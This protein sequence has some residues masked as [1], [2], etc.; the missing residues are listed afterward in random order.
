VTRVIIEGGRVSG[1]EAQ[2]GEKTV[3]IRARKGVIFA[4]GGFAHNLDLIQLHQRFLYGSCAVP[5]SMGDFVSIA[6]LAGARMGQMDL[7]WRT[8]VVL[9]EALKNHVL[10]V[11]VFFVPSDSMVIVNKYGRRV[12]DE[13]RDYN[14]RTRAHFAY[15]PVAE[16]YPNQLLFMVFDE[17][18]RDAFGGSYPIPLDKDTPYLIAGNNL[19][20]LSNMIQQR[21]KSYADRTGGVQLADNFAPTLTDTITRFNEFAKNGQDPEFNR[22]LH[23]YDREWQGYFSVMRAGSTQQANNMPNSTMY[24]L[25]AQGPYYAIVLAPGALD[26]NGGPLINEHAQVLSSDGKPIPGLYGAGNCICSPTRD[27]YMGAGGTIG[28]GMTYG[29]IAALHAASQSGAAG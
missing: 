13:K 28:P 25:A 12:V 14:D 19:A 15:D 29:Y 6:G 22:G 23:R 1:V 4:T 16:D 9:E 2:H 26:T 7:A 21:L 8:Q 11:G 17:R 18:S 20:E 24:P 10:G 3:R 5:Q 27:A